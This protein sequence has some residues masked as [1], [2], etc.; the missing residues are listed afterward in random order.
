M[1]MK[2]IFTLCVGL[3]AALSMQ[4]QSDFPVQFADKDGNLV[5]DGSVL[6]LT[7]AEDDGFGSIMVPSHLFVKNTTSDNVQV[8]GIYSITT[9]SNGAFQTCFPANCIQKNAVGEYETESGPL[10]GNQLK[11]MM[12]EW[13]PV[14]EGTCVVT[15]QLVTYKQNAITRTWNKDKYGPTVTLNFAYGVSIDIQGDVN[16]DSQVGIGDIISVTNFMANGE[17]SGITLEQADVNSDGLVGIGDIITIAN[18]MAGN[19]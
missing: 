4:A 17:Q 19:E 13:L 9:M 3:L 16:G 5:A 12:T 8:G 18:I 14:A 10:M 6:K 11:D 7:E 1:F 2:K 15:Y